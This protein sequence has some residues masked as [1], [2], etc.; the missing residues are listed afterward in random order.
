[1][2]NW[3]KNFCEE[4]RI[5]LFD[6]NSYIATNDLLEYHRTTD[7]LHFTKSTDLVLQEKYMLFL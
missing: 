5:P 4:K 6:I 7:G 2:N 1:M 3:L